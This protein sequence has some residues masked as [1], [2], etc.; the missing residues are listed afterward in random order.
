VYWILRG[1]NG[2]VSPGNLYH[3]HMVWRSLCVRGLVD[4]P[5]APA[6]KLLRNS[7]ADRGGVKSLSANLTETDP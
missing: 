3:G 4:D 2:D 5:R 6:D 7:R 1:F